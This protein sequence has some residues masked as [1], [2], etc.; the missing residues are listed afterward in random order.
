M[1]GVPFRLAQVEASL[2]V[3]VSEAWQPVQLLDF[4]LGEDGQAMRVA[5]NVRDS[6]CLH[7]IA[8]A[9]SLTRPKGPAA[10][11]AAKRP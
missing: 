11:Q 4:V 7:S 5:G 2:P 9:S 1:N 8:G 10:N 3:L 6:G